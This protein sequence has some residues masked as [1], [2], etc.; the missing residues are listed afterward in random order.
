MTVGGLP[1][2]P[3]MATSPFVVQLRVGCLFVP[4]VTGGCVTESPTL[5]PPAGAP[6]SPLLPT[7]LAQVSLPP[8]LAPLE[9]LEV[10]A[11]FTLVDFFGLA[12]FF[13]GLVLA[14]TP[15]HARLH[16]LDVLRPRHSISD[17][18]RLLPLADFPIIRERSHLDERQRQN[19][20]APVGAVA[21]FGRL[22]GDA[23]DADLVR[24]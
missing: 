1:A 5:S 13:T 2:G 9:P 21:R 15:L 18:P 7:P 14:S 16:R 3:A 8:L 11:A 19:G 10:S 22:L 17:A 20:V 24:D 4:P 6:G 23:D 12:G